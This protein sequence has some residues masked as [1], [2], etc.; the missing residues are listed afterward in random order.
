MFLT[1]YTA[2][3]RVGRNLDAPHPLGWP[4]V[5]MHAK[6]SAFSYA[7]H[8]TSLSLYTVI[9][10]LETHEVGRARFAV[11]PDRYLIL[12]DHTRHAHAVQDG[13]ETLSVRFRS[14]LGADVF[15][16]FATPDERQL[17]D[18]RFRLERPH[19][20][21]RTY[22]RD[23]RL[24]FLMGLLVAFI[25]EGVGQDALEQ[26]VQPVLARL[27]TLHRDLDAEIERL[28][29]AKRSTREEL[30]RR[31]HTAR[32]YIEASYLEKLNLSGIADVVN[33]S[34]HH[35]LRLFKEAFN[36]TPYQFV[37]AK[38]LERALELLCS[39]DQDVT[40]ICFDLGFESLG[41]FSRDFKRRFGR[42]PSQ[43]RRVN[44]TPSETSA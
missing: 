42:S 22:A 25:F 6:S 40:N 3:E 16:A 24:S 30:Y 17:D 2:L 23:P 43:F 7:S 26:A 37:I 28:P 27:L 4:N 35:F 41:S 21:E 15:T 32:D 10:G 19:F 14:G 38:R 13:T 5:V 8:T 33:L 1:E 11:T 9:R 18:P 34:P 44:E 20:F 36:T 31:L 12:N 29:A 39:T